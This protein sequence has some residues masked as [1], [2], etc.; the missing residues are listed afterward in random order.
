[1]PRDE[2]RSRNFGYFITAKKPAKEINR[3]L[4]VEYPL[5]ILFTIYVEKYLRY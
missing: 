1:M 2:I 3:E 5:E 4:R